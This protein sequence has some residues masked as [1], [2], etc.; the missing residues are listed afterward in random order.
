MQKNATCV[1]LY[2]CAGIGDLGLKSCGIETIVA[3]ELLVERA[4]LMQNN[5]P[6]T[7]VICGDIWTNQDSIV[8]TAQDRL[9]GKQLDLIM[10]SP[11]CQSMSSNG[12]GAMSA[13]CKRGKR[14]EEDLRSSLIIPVID[15]T[16]RLMPKAVIIENVAGMRKEV[17]TNECGDKELILDMLYRRLPDY[18]LRSAR[19][20][21]GYVGATPSFEHPFSPE[22]TWS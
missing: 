16:L 8:E 21:V 5:F 13:A 14:V 7:A 19:V 3:N 6:E 15:L 10:A 9:F 11:P 18:V 12:R 2:S 1:S 17:I 4:K 22:K 20:V